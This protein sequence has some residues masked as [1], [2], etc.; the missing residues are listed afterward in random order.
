MDQCPEKK[1]N[2][3]IDN[4]Y[5]VNDLTN[6]TDSC[7]CQGS[8]NQSLINEK[9]LEKKDTKKPNLVNNIKNES[10]N[11][12]INNNGNGLENLNSKTIKTYIYNYNLQNIDNNKEYNSYAYNYNQSKTKVN[13]GNQTNI[14]TNKNKKKNN[15][16][17]DNNNIYKSPLQEKAN[18]QISAEKKVEKSIEYNKGNHNNYS[19]YKNKNDKA[20]IKQFNP[21]K[22]IVGRGVKNN[23]EK[24][25]KVREDYFPVR[26]ADEDQTELLEF[27]KNVI[28]NKNVINNYLNMEK[29]NSNDF[30]GRTIVGPISVFKKESLVK[31]ENVGK[32]TYMN[33]VV[34]LIS[35]IDRIIIYYLNK[36][37]DITEKIQEVPLSYAFSRLIFHLYPFPQDELQNSYSILNF[38]RI[39][40][41]LNPFFRGNST[42]NAI[43]FLVFL[44]DTL[45]QE[46]VALNY[47]N[48]NDIQEEIDNTNFDKY[49]QYIRNKEHSIIFKSFGWINKTLKKCSNCDYSSTTYQKFFENDLDI[50][51]ALDKK[52]KETK[53]SKNKI[54]FIYDCLKYLNL[55]EPK[56]IMKCEKCCQKS[57]EYQS[58]INKTPTYFIF[59][60]KANESENIN[61]MNLNKIKIKI[62]EKLDLSEIINQ[63]VIYNLI[64]FVAFY[65]DFQDK[66]YREYKAFCRSQ[67]GTNKSWYVF[68]NDD[69]NTIS[70][71]N[72]DDNIKSSEILPVILLYKKE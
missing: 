13:K 62:D 15:G 4:N 35:N 23:E 45:H 17:S 21:Q 26:P 10:H 40:T 60:L 64:G 8:Y 70:K 66:N 32:T 53:K 65:Y 46:D 51:G 52:I 43:D 20:S 56:K 72:I 54:I 47:K 41:I 44:L 49:Y 38:H 59:T 30:L 48:S 67:I 19:N 37:N 31:L 58:S 63:K 11:Y 29:N 24:K 61:K 42:K 36:L 3:I 1:K 71:I 33:A 25:D 18:N 7:R 9:L 68:E 12:N 6:I 57:I 5:Y 34:R 22:E 16:K 69:K 50:K 27:P 2:S 14:K 39:A 55:E 28:E